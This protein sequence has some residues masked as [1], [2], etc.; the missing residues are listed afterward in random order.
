MKQ[1]NGDH[2]DPPVHDLEVLSEEELQRLKSDPGLR[3]MIEDSIRDE[4]AGRVFSWSAVKEAMQRGNLR[5]MLQKH[6]RH[7]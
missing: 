6:R 1:H 5:E 7:G 2:H 3:R 4:Q